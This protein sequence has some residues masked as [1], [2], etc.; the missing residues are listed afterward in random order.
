MPKGLASM[1]FKTPWVVD[2]LAPFFEL[3]L[4]GTS[5]WYYVTYIGCVIS[6]GS[7]S[8]AHCDISKCYNMFGRFMERFFPIFQGAE[9]Q[10]RVFG[11]FQTVEH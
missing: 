6:L 8:K 7:I 3:E 9:Y 2:Q 10:K 4:Q 11:T 5:M 1:L